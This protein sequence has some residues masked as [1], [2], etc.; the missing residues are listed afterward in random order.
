VLGFWGGV[1]SLGTIFLLIL[2]SQRYCCVKKKVSLLSTPSPLATDVQLDS[3][4]ILP[5]H[6]I[7]FG[8]RLK[9]ITYNSYIIEKI[10]YSALEMSN[11]FLS[12]R[13]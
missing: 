8:H 9:S 11:F 3:K 4:A 1:G 10:Y 2:V 7:S 12:H 5:V 6:R 13:Q